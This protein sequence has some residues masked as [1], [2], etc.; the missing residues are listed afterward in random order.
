M[1]DYTKGQFINKTHVILRS[2]SLSNLT[3]NFKDVDNCESWERH[4][5]N[6]DCEQHS[7]YPSFLFCSMCDIDLRY[8]FSAILEGHH[9]HKREL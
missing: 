2:H 4:G 3:N 6:Q 8:A 1:L 5:K 9:L 7:S